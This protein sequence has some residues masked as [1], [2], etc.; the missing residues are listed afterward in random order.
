MHEMSLTREAL[1]A[2][3]EVGENEHASKILSV[4]FSIGEGRDVIEPLFCKLFHYLAK[5]SIA[6]DSKLYVNHVPM[7]LACRSCGC[8]YPADQRKQDSWPCP[9]C[10]K[11]DYQLFSG[12]EFAIDK[13]EIE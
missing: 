1:D 4:Q 13:I 3:I 9:D 7:R 6:Q 8:V 11:K 2:V 5:D 10:T 12:M